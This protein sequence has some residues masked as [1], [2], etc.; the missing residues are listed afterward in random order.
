[1]IYKPVSPPQVIAHYPGNFSN[2]KLIVCPAF[3]DGYANNHK[4]VLPLLKK[5]QLPATFFVIAI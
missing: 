1:M 2:A 5:Y 3:D 4:Y